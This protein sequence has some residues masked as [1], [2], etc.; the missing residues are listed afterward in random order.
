MDGLSENESREECARNELELLT[1]VLAQH[2]A[3]TPDWTAVI[4]EID[5]EGIGFRC[6]LSRDDDCARLRCETF[7]VTFRERLE[8]EIRQ[9]RVR[10]G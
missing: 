4:E 5:D 10:S 1:Q 6:V 9:G 7:A 2:G 8:I 3:I